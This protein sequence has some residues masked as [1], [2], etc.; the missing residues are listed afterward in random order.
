MPSLHQRPRQ[1]L[2]DA[3]IPGDPAHHKRPTPPGRRWP[4]PVL[5]VTS[6]DGGLDALSAGELPRKTF[7][8]ALYRR[9]RLRRGETAPIWAASGV[10]KTMLSLSLAM[11]MATGGALVPGSQGSPVVSCTSTARCMRRT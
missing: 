3:S 7:L 2:S 5:C 11:A 9:P 4:V 8:T 1:G 6:L 10:G